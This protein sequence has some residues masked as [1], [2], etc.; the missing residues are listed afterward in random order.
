MVGAQGLLGYGLVSVLGAITA[1]VFEGRNY[2]EIFSGLRLTMFAGGAAGP[3]ITG[4]LH[5]R[6]GSYAPGFAIAL[7]ICGVSAGAMWL[8][9]PRRVRAVAGRLARK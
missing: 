2:G 9:G 4:L 7:A 6:T 5:D 1:E 3:W 8:A